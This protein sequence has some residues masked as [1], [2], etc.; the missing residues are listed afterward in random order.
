MAHLF[1]LGYA[2]LNLEAFQMRFQSNMN[3]NPVLWLVS[4]VLHF[5]IGGYGRVGRRLLLTALCRSRFPEGKSMNCFFCVFYGYF[6]TSVNLT[7]WCC[8]LFCSCKIMSLQ[9]WCWTNASCNATGKMFNQLGAEQVPVS[10]AVSFHVF[11]VTPPSCWTSVSY[12]S[13]PASLIVSEHFN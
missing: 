12:K 11:F 4:L 8:Y 5:M 1:M 10:N 6:L 3:Q 13:T 2:W 7:L 9:F